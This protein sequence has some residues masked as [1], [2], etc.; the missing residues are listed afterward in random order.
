MELLRLK[1]RG[2]DQKPSFAALLPPH[3]AVTLL[4]FNGIQGPMKINVLSPIPQN[5]SLLTNLYYPCEHLHLKH[6]RVNIKAQRLL[7]NI[8]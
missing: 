4:H 2:E 1:Q 7:R 5:K 3:P 6:F 8:S